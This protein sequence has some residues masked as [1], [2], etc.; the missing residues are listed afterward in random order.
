VLPEV[1]AERNHHP[2]KQ[3]IKGAVHPV[4]LLRRA[5]VA[6]RVAVG[7]HQADRYRAIYGTEKH[8]DYYIEMGEKA[9]AGALP[10]DEL[11]HLRAELA[12]MESKGALRPELKRLAA[13]LDALAA[14][15]RAV[16]AAEPVHGDA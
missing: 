6:V 7:V 9:R 8:E 16:R 1:I 4:A 14:A 3:S 15:P 13:D 10:G 5:A 12:E 11:A 2:H